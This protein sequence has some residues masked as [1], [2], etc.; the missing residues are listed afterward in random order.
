MPTI[1]TVRDLK[2][3]VEAIKDEDNDKKV[4]IASDEELNVLYQESQLAKLRG[5]GYVLFGLSVA[6]FEEE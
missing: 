2:C 1:K 3:A 5:K 4:F 6:E